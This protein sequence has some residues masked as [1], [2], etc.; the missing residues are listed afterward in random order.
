MDVRCGCS[1][2]PLMTPETID[3][4]TEIIRE[5]GTDAWFTMDTQELLP[6]AYR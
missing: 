1:D 3:F 2:E 4:V 5:K 6:P